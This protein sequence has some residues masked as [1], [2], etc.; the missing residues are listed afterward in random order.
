MIDWKNT[1]AA[2]WRPYSQ[3]LRAVKYYDPIQL[4]E[5]YGIERQKERIMANTE[6]FLAGQPCN[7]ALLWGSRGT[8]KSSVVKALLNH[9]ADKGLRLLEVDK[10]DLAI[11]PEIVDEIREEP[12]RF[13][14]F[15]DDL[16]F[17][18]G[19]NSYKHLKSVMEGSI[20]L[21]PENVRIYATS[22]RRHLLPESHSDNAGGGV[23]GGELHLGD[24]L[25]EK[26]SL[27][28]RFG[29]R[30]SFY[31]ISQVQYYEIIDS[32]FPEVE[33]R[34]QLHILAQR[35]ATEKGGRS[36][37]TARQFW[38]QYGGEL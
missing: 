31:P 37:R 3:R 29:L 12:Y 2:V 21:P 33:N 24:A 23:K 5:L 15:S 34:E 27:A 36:G 28:D 20:E 14:V 11:L 19:E 17:A 32:Y 4:D 25:E 13:I 1:K 30:L 38:N 18:E 35:F 10:E 26:I 7:H 9:Y 6:R 16:S 8:G 22:N